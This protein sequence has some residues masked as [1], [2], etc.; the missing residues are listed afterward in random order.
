[1]THA[2]AAAARSSNTATARVCSDLK[3]QKPYRP[4]KKSISLLH[5]FT[6]EEI[7]PNR[8]AR[9]INQRMKVMDGKCDKSDI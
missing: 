9:K 2:P 3:H 1:M 4:S 8:A 5:P 7:I 6:S